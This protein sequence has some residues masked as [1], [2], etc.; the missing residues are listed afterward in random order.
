V[1]AADDLAA[2]AFLRTLEKIGQGVRPRSFRAYLFRVLR[3][4]WID[5]HRREAKVQLT[6]GLPDEGSVSSPRVGWHP[7]GFDV[8]DYVT[9]RLV[10]GSALD[11][12]S[13]RQRLVLWRTLVEGD[14][15]D[16]VAAVSTALEN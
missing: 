2:E 4:H 13:Q 3:N 5:R 15:L 10:M 16:E 6:G 8:A 12:L 7:G 11:Q 1:H 14:R 9:T